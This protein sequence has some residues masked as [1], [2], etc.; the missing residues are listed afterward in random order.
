VADDLDEA[1][2][3]ALRSMFVLIERLHR[4]SRADAVMLASVSVDLRVTQIVNGVVG[5]H[6]VLPPGAIR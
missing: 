6:A 2:Q 4:V 3:L 1:T 5:A